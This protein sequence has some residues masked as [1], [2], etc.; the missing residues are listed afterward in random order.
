MSRCPVPAMAELEEEAEGTFPEVSEAQSRLPL[1][2][3]KF[4]RLWD[5][6]VLGKKLPDP[7]QA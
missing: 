3:E 1:F 2:W 4:L 7:R 5:S 6:P